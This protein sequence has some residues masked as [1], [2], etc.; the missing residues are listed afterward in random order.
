MGEAESEQSSGLVTEIGKGTTISFEPLRSLSRMDLER[1]SSAN[2]FG[3][4]LLEE[5]GPDRASLSPTVDSEGLD[6][7]GCEAIDL[8]GESSAEEVS[9]SSSDDNVSNARETYS[10]RGQTPGVE[11]SRVTVLQC[12]GS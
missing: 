7:D 2:D 9:I 5:D 12:T 10:V 3:L 11:A 6:C 8:S 1:P 4:L